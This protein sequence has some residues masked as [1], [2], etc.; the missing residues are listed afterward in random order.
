LAAWNETWFDLTLLLWFCSATL[1][2]PFSFMSSHFSLAFQAI[3]NSSNRSN[4]FYHVLNHW[5]KMFID[6]VN[7]SLK[8]VFS[9]KGKFKRRVPFV[10]VLRNE[11]NH[12]LNVFDLVVLK[13]EFLFEIFFFFVKMLKAFIVLWCKRSVL[14]L[15][16][17]FLLNISSL[18]RRKGNFFNLF[19]ET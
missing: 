18:L 9:D 14:V 6:N 19:L 17:K 3:A 1:T 4:L 5:K 11:F 10:F 16:F 8:L 15:E 2:K 13:N 12:F 7:K